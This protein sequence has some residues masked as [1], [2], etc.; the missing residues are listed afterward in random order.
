MFVCIL[1]EAI[2]SGQSS[3]AKPTLSTCVCVC[4]WGGGAN[5]LNR[6]TDRTTSRRAVRRSTFRT[7]GRTVYL[8]LRRLRARGSADSENTGIGRLDRS[9]RFEFV[10]IACYLPFGTFIEKQLRVGLSHGLRVIYRPG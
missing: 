4:M 6:V 10:S 2:S 8:C 3:R 7:A 1:S 5:R 9:P